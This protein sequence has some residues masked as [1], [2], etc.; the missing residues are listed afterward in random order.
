LHGSCFLSIFGV[1][2]FQDS[3]LYFSWSPMTTMLTQGDPLD[4]TMMSLLAASRTLAGQ[5]EYCMDY[6]A[7]VRAGKVKA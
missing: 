1:F 2:Y 6:I 5:D 3:S 7:G 4:L